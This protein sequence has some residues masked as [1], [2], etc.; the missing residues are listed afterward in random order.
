MKLLMNED[1]DRKLNYFFDGKEWVEKWEVSDV[2]SRMIVENH[3]QELEPIRNQVLAGKLSPL[4][5]HI[6]LRVFTVGLVSAYTGIPK[7]HIKKHLKPE[8]FNQLDEETLE[9][10]ASALGISV[11]ELKKV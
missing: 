5:Y 4:A 2:A 11:E 9:K 1:Q 3:I 7:R 6:P 8:K 10:S